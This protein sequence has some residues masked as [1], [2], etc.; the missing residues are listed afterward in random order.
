MAIS[1][2]I[3]LKALQEEMKK[4][5][6]ELVETL[7]V[8]V[9]GKQGPAVRRR[10]ALTLSATFKTGGSGK[11]GSVITRCNDL[12]KMKDDLLPLETRLG[13][14]EVMG[15]LSQLNGISVPCRC[16]Y[17]ILLYSLASRQVPFSSTQRSRYLKRSNLARHEHAFIST[18]VLTIICSRQ[19]ALPLFLRS[20]AVLTVSV[21]ISR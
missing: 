12:L 19:F 6:D 10:V 11:V 14:I 9:N 18:L 1:K 2:P 13:A 20:R 16:T 21:R 17:Y 5:Y 3:H 7:A 8:M 4:R 15:T